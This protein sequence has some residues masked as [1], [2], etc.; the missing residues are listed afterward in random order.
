M[1]K[2]DDVMEDF[3]DRVEKMIRPPISEIHLTG[4]IAKIEGEAEYLIEQLGNIDR[5]DRIKHLPEFSK[6][7]DFFAYSLLEKIDARLKEITN[8]RNQLYIALGYP[9]SL[10]KGL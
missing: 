2:R 7:I 3:S 1:T 9:S 4:I 10:I 6:G 5:W 8:L